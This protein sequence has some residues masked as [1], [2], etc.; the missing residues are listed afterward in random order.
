MGMKSR[1]KGKVGEREIAA[2]V[3]DLTG[4]TVRRKVRQLDG[5]SD[6]E[7]VPGWSVEVKRHATATRAEIRDWWDQAVHQAKA[8]AT[9]PVLFY[10]RD[11]DEWRAVWPAASVLGIEG[12][13]DWPDYAWTVEGTVEAWAS[14]ARE[15]VSHRAEVMA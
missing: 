6:L 9:L 11:R 5:E 13:G 3:R 4:W 1:S 7:G 8:E 12:K 2:I 14:C 10:R 15:V